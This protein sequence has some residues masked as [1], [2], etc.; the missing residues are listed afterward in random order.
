MLM[1]LLVCPHCKGEYTFEEFEE[2][3]IEDVL[4]ELGL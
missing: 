1:P 3:E 2:E 4:K